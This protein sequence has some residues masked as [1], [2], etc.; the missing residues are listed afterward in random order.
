MQ[1][2]RDTPRQRENLQTSHPQLAASGPGGD[3]AEAVAPPKPKPAVSSKK[4]GRNDKVVVQN[5]TSG[6]KKEM[7]YKKAQ[8]LLENEG[9]TIVE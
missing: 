9:W 6:E 1:Q 8:P 2:Q 3:N 5:L 7:K 4:Y